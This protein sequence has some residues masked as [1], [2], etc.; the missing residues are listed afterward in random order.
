MRKILNGL[1]FDTTKATLIGEASYSYPGDFHHF[2]AGLYKTPRSGRYFLA[3]SGGP[4]SRFSQS[5]GQNEWSGGS[6][7][8]PLD[9]EDALEWAEQNLTPEEIELGFGATIKDA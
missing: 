1:R 2:V 8:I 4:M 9:A 3:G 6:D 7:I 5:V